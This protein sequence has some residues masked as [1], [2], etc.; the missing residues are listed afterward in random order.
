MAKSY[1]R[2]NPNV[3]LYP[4]LPKPL[5]LVTNTII[6]WNTRYMQAIIDQLKN[7][8]YLINEDDLKHIS[9]C[10]FKHINKHGRLTFNVEEEL[11][12]KEL[13]PL[14]TH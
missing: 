12:R 9:P 14:R 4:L 1:D 13:R 5:T 3:Q 2:F 11:N 8:G 6:V 7:E 10:R